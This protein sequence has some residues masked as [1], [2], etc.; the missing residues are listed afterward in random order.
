M[1]Q[2]PRLRKG[3]IA[4]LV[5][6]AG[7]VAAAAFVWRDDIMRTGLD[8]KVPFQTYQPPAAPDY[9][10]DASWWLR[11]RGAPRPGDPP[12]DVFFVGPTVYTGGEDW[13]APLDDRD[14]ERTF[15]RVV[16]PNYV[17]PFASVGRIFAPRYRQASLYSLLTLRDDAREARRFAYGDV[18]QAFRT[19]LAQ[20]DRSRPLVIVGVEQGGVLAERLTARLDPE[21]RR[22]VAVVYLIETLTPVGHTPL[23]ACRV[24]GQTGCVAAWTTVSEFD[25]ERAQAITA[26]AVTWSP[27]G[28]LEGLGGRPTLCFNPLLHAAGDAAAPARLSLGATNATGLEW[29]ARPAFLMGQV[30]ARCEGGLLRVSRRRSP[31]LNPSGSWAE[32]R[33]IPPYNLFYADLEEDAEVRVAAFQ[34][35]PNLRP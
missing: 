22:R 9:A 10:Q 33:M 20:A 13:N 16:A 23:P 32:R 25:V 3:L 17:G 7:L 34:R 19:Y 18:E 30:S 1:A 31:S 12:A 6:L 5:V 8:P 26:R 21:T 15:R 35:Q 29:G 24:S 27:A 28:D 11:P 2:R 4:G 14:A